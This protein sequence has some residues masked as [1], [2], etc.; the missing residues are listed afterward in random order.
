VR[1]RVEMPQLNAFGEVDEHLNMMGRRAMRRLTLA[2][3]LHLQPTR[4]HHSWVY[5]NAV[6]RGLGL[7]DGYYFLGGA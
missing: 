2:S 1:D 3:G 5:D 6:V 7:D 4:F